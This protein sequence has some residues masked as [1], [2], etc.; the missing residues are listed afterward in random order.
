MCFGKTVSVDSGCGRCVCGAGG[1][2]S[3]VCIVVF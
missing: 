1:A 2:Q 3:R